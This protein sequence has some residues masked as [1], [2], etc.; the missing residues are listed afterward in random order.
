MLIIGCGYMGRL[1]GANYQSRGE[2]VTGVVRSEDSAR[3]LLELGI[4]PLRADLDAAPAPSLPSRGERL[5]Y[6]APPPDHGR[7]DT[8]LRQVLAGFRVSGQPRRIVYISTTG[9]YGDCGGDWVD[10]TRPLNPQAD[11][12]HRRVDAEQAL[13][14]WAA[15]TGG[16]LVILRVAGIYGRGRLPLERLRKGLPLVC[17]AESPYTNRVH[18]DDLLQVCVA[19]ME[20]GIPGRIYHAC[21]GNPSTMIEYFRC[22]AELAGLPA[23]PEI[24]LAEAESRLSPGMMSYMRESRR[25]SNRRILDELGVILKYPTLEEGLVASFGPRSGAS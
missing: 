2:A 11:R 6:F 7:T 5:F 17:A 20:R 22:V 14:D 23:P 12:S 24:S 25:L 4:R 18:A 1:V 3:E 16:E 10:E 15:A 21:D 8:R 13:R 19:A 9:V